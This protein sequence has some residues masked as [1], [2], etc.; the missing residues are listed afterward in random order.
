MNPSKKFT[1]TKNVNNKT[2][3]EQKKGEATYSYLQ[4][5]VYFNNFRTH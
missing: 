1:R 4:I 5:S 3:E 2:L